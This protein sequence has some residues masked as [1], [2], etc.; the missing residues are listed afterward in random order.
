M[1]HYVYVGSSS[2]RRNFKYKGDL[3][4]NGLPHG[5]GEAI[6]TR[7]HNYHG[8]WSH[9]KM[10]GLGIYYYPSGTFYMGQFE[11]N[12]FN[13]DGFYLSARKKSKKNANYKCS[14][15]PI[16][17]SY[18]G[19]WVNDKRH[20]KGKS[21]L[22]N[23][24]S[25]DGIWSNDKRLGQGRFT[26]PNRGWIEGQ[27]IEDEINGWARRWSAATKTF[28]NGFYKNGKKHGEHQTESSNKIA[29]NYYYE[30]RKVFYDGTCAICQESLNPFMMHVACGE[31]LT[32]TAFLDM[33]DEERNDLPMQ[34]IPIVNYDVSI[35]SC[36]HVYHTDCIHKWKTHA[37]TQKQKTE[38]PNCKHEDYDVYSN[39]FPNGFA[40]FN[41]IF[42]HH[43]SRNFN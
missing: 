36:G 4:E 10:H 14:G 7:G 33:W 28:E 37:P 42:A 19:Q 17:I 39:Q 16:C 23:G 6:C 41:D 30:G 22:G 24:G 38:C 40:G 15:Y 43:L 35:T 25:F 21:T 29:T 32:G 5:K 34:I 20:G 3:D 1:F 2:W 31:E 9:G 26:L 18:E 12:R 13:G 27:W 11:N 8:Q